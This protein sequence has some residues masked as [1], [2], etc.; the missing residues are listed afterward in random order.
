MA[1]FQRSSE[2][3]RTLVTSGDAMFVYIVDFLVLT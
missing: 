1:G 3:R 2:R